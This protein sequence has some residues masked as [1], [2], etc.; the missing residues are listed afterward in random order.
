[1]D[2]ITI[3]GIAF[4]VG[5]LGGLAGHALGTRLIHSRGGYEDHEERLALIEGVVRSVQRAQKAD[6]MRQLRAAAP[7]D[8]EL[9]AE[10]DA[11]AGAAAPMSP[12][13]VKK[14]LR[15]R[16]FGRRLQ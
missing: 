4:A 1:M 2:W 10:P 6:R 5:G 15:A 3:V 12:A 8:R 9:P 13:E 7:A 14:A 11:G 16:V